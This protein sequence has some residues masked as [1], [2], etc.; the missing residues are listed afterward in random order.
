M[1]ISAASS[2]PPPKKKPA[3]KS[4]PKKK[5]PPKTTRK[6]VTQ[7]PVSKPINNGPCSAMKNID[8]KTGV[9]VRGEWNHQVKFKFNIN[10][11]SKN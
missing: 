4:P 11:F 6:T 7:K 1:K 2:K 10:E 3:K 9:N 8:G 5:P